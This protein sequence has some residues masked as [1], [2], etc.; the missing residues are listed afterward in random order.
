MPNLKFQG[1]EYSDEIEILDYRR[2]ILKRKMLRIHPC[3][4]QPYIFWQLLINRTTKETN[5][6]D[7]QKTPNDSLQKDMVKMQAL[8]AGDLNK[9]GSLN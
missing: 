2:D 7:A 3:V 8:H 9:T 6:P 4:L 1:C 5:Q